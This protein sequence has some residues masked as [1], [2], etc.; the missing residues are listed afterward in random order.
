M[1]RPL[2]AFLFDLAGTTV[3]DDGLVQD[4]FLAAA[5]GAGL[6]LDPEVLKA[7][8]GW[9][10]QRVFAT[11][12]K[13]AGRDPSPA[14]D[15]AAD[16]EVQYAAIVAERGLRTTP[17]VGAMIE[18]LLDRRI[19]VGF[20]TGFSRA[21]ADRVLAAVGFSG[22]A[23]VASTEVAEGRP[24]PDLIRL[25]MRRL[26][27]GDPGRVGIAGDTPSD[28]EAGTRA[29]CRLVVGVGCGTHSLGELES[30]L[31][32]HLLP[33]LSSLLDVIDAM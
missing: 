3:C 22:F 21:T 14:A 16:F 23:S 5:H 33:D 10:K 27:L 32:T 9:H 12:L 17:G 13:E 6:T 31:H 28:L 4:A 1:N 26:G 11:C 30:H 15:L 18:G 25:A 20:T 24:A 7:R 8:M 2:D 29:G 19:A